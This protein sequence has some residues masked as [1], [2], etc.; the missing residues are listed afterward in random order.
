M[1]LRKCLQVYVYLL[2]VAILNSCLTGEQE[3]V[4]EPDIYVGDSTKPALVR[5][6]DERMIKCEAEE[7]NN[8]ICLASSEAEHLFRQ[9]LGRQQ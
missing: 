1:I 4:W 2:T 8:Y 3:A 9:C 5:R 7:F 6:I